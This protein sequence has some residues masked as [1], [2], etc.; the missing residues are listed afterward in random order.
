LPIL[1]VPLYERE[2][3][4]L[5]LLDR[6]GRDLYS[7]VEPAAV[8]HQD[9]PVQVRKDGGRY[10]LS[11]RLP[12]TAKADLDLL[13]KGEDLFVKVGP[14]KRTLMLPSVLARLEVADAV[15]EGD[16]LNVSFQRRESARKSNEGGA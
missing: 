6:L 5:D 4:G 3:V 8:L 9:E 15:F 16:R 13:R 14:Y 2:M 12:F 11:L 1:T 10:V 7:R